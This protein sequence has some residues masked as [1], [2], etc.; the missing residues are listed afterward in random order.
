MDSDLGARA[1]PTATIISEL[2]A[3]VGITPGLGNPSELPSPL[4][5]RSE[6]P[7]A[8][9]QF[10]GRKTTLSHITDALIERQTV[11]VHGLPGIGKSD[12]AAEAGRALLEG[13]AFSGALW[14]ESTDPWTV[15]SLCDAI[16]RSLGSS[17][18]TLLGGS[19][20]Y[21]ATREP[22]ASHPQV[23]VI[24]D[25]IPTD[26]VATRFVNKCLP[27]RAGFLATSNRRLNAFRL[28]VPLRALELGEAVELFLDRAGLE[29]S[30]DTMNAICDLLGNHPLAIVVAAGRHQVEGLPL[31]TL[32]RQL[33]D[34]KTRLSSLRL[35]ESEDPEHSVRAAL[36]VSWADLNIDQRHLLTCLSDFVGKTTLELLCAYADIN[37]DECNGRIGELFARSL[38]ERDGPYLDLHQLIRDFARSESMR[39]RQATFSEVGRSVHAYVQ[40][41]APQPN[42]KSSQDRLELERGNIAHVIRQAARADSLELKLIGLQCSAPLVD[43]SGVLRR[44][45]YSGLRGELARIMLQIL[46]EVGDDL[47]A[48]EIAP[49]AASA[50]A[51]QGGFDEALRLLQ[52]CQDIL[53]RNGDNERSSALL[54]E[55]G[56]VASRLGGAEYAYDCYA[57]AQR[58]AEKQHD[59]VLIA[60]SKGQTGLL[61]LHG[62]LLAPAHLLYSE[63][64]ELYRSE[65]NDRGMAACLHHLGDISE[66]L[67]YTT[68]AER[69]YRESVDLERKNED[70]PG[71]VITLSEMVK[72]PFAEGASES[73]AAEYQGLLEEYQT[74]GNLEGSASVLLLFGDAALTSAD[75]ELAEGYY[76]SSLRISRQVGDQ[77]GIAVALGQLSSIA[78]SSGNREAAR[79][80]AQQSLDAYSAIGD[81]NGAALCL[82]QLGQLAESEKELELAR[83]YYMRSF[84]LWQD[85]GAPAAFYAANAFLKAHERLGEDANG[86]LD[87]RDR[88]ARG[89][90]VPG[91]LDETTDP[92]FS[93][94][95][96]FRRW[97]IDETTNYLNENV[98]TS[99]CQETAELAEL[100]GGFAPAARVAVSFINASGSSSSAYC[101]EFR[102]LL[103]QCSTHDQYSDKY[104][105][106]MTTACLIS[107]RRVN[108]VSVAASDLLKLCLFLSPAGVQY[109]DLRQTIASLPESLTSVVQDEGELEQQVELLRRFS[110]IESYGDSITPAPLVQKVLVDCMEDSEIH[111]WSNAAIRFI[112][113]ILPLDLNKLT[114]KTEYD[115]LLDHAVFSSAHC[116]AT[117]NRSLE[118]ARVMNNL[119]AFFEMYGQLSNSL[120][121]YDYA[122]VITEELTGSSSPET[123]FQLNNLATALLRLGNNEL[124]KA[125]YERALNIEVPDEPEYWDS[126]GKL[127]SNYGHALIREGDLDKARDHFDSARQ[128]HEQLHGRQH[129]AV[130]I[131]IHNLGVVCMHQQAWKEAKDLLEQSMNIL[132]KCSLAGTLPYADTLMHL[133]PVL[134]HLGDNESAHQALLDALTILEQMLGEMHPAVAEAIFTLGTFFESTGD[135][136][137]A[138]VEYDRASNLAEFAYGRRSARTK[139]FWKSRN[140][141]M[142]SMEN[143]S[144]SA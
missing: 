143:P 68:P 14:L 135:R 104:R 51:A 54:I 113:S 53:D 82:F 123:A 116:E 58:A 75:L 124:A 56:N 17:N 35:P 109:D 12:L 5:V 83:N 4:S 32:H 65:Q 117:G 10:V 130:A 80:Y 97:T 40:R 38:V 64:L 133:G 92:E 120:M 9:F 112:G 19:E 86:P 111:E 85:S 108:D 96:G 125:Q 122:L 47:L 60:A 78:R 144:Q 76:E 114:S 132:E 118:E 126:V 6:L 59:S 22:L 138:S 93:E 95:L 106:I 26:Q 119:G 41:Y 20:K 105:C 131:D 129:L 44:R 46:D 139:F 102:R 16:A 13:K 27:K 81:R 24:V 89:S 134:F 31:E 99:K 84:E 34:E 61:A 103:S 42:I 57:R 72:L 71:V 127:V 36:G 39:D 142:S 98:V 15:D 45:G 77:R 87:K 100:L 50:I 3:R 52:Q 30:D 28:R 49:I 7:F 63:S 115:R 137:R 18:I 1:I 101:Q 67:G 136:T 29:S 43:D 128:I 55:L 37:E 23:L 94:K 121:V 73:A 90:A 8:Q 70:L 2:G 88:V 141:L 62:N 110:L 48:A 74:K 107:L 140:E 33:A 69:F 25:G 66:R 11:L 79:D 91:S 21:A